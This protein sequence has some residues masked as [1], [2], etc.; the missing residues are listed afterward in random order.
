MYATAGNLSESIR[1]YLVDVAYCLNPIIFWLA[2]AAIALIWTRWKQGQWRVSLVILT[3]ALVP[4]GYYV[5]NLYSNM[6]PILLPGL[7]P[8]EPDS[9]INV[10]YGSV[11]ATTFPILAAVTIN[12]IL[13]QM[14]HHPAWSLLII[15]PLFLPDP[16][17]V[18]SL[19]RADAQLTDN[20]LYR[21]AIRNQSFWMPP[22]VEVAERLNQEMRLE[23]GDTGHVL[24][25]TRIVHP[26]V[27]ASGIPMRRFISEMN[28][29]RWEQNLNEIDPEIRWVIT[30]EGDQLWHARG[31]FLQ[32]EFVE[33]ARAKT[34]STGT[35]HLYRRP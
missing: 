22:F 6:V 27:W 25:N 30:E 12:V 11:M 17:P 20:L 1:T 33:V 34:A 4:F 29:Q 10:R 19:E 32:R 28:K 5:F 18:A 16:I 14:N 2:L 31:S 26:V 21:E 13:R 24:T 15:T 3:S 23:G 7:L 8:S 9:I 35:V